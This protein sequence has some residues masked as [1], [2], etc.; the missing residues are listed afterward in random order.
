MNSPENNPFTPGRTVPVEFFVGRLTQIKDVQYSIGRAALGK[1][2][3]IFLTG[4]R[5][6][7]KSSFA[8][9]IRH[10]ISKNEQALAIHV[11]LGGISTLEELVQR[12]YDELLKRSSEQT[13][14]SK[15]KDMFGNYVQEIGLF[16]VSV[17]FNPPQ[18]KLTQLVRDF[19]EALQNLL[20]RLDGT[21]STIFIALDDINGLAETQLFADW[22]KSLVD[23]VSTHYESFPVSF[24]LI[25]LPERRRRL[26]ELQPSLMRI[27]RIVEIERLSDEEASQFYLQTFASTNIEVTPGALEL[28]IKRA[29]GLPSLMQEIGESVFRRNYDDRISGLDALYGVKDAAMVIGTKYLDPVFS[30]SIRSI[31]YR[32]ILKKLFGEYAIQTFTRKSARLSLNERER[33]VFD[34]LLTRLKKFGVIEAD[35]EAERGTYKFVNAMY[36]LYMW[37]V[38]QED[39]KK[40]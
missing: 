13:W 27:F 5:G 6:M 25:G 30:E 8:A 15:I 31:Q 23:K 9:F 40:R 20:K 3:N 18:E 21:K 16:G 7:G 24:M 2:E 28:M 26:A 39:L 19:P 14:F 1:Q 33:L 4:P 17:G 38:A 11:Y 22:F 29:S 35:I 37:M 10:L 12:I 32:S 34:N 36:P